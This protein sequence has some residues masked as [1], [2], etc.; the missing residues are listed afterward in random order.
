MRPIISNCSDSNSKLD[1][2]LKSK[3]SVILSF[4]VE[5]CQYSKSPVVSQ[6]NEFTTYFI[7]FS[8]IVFQSV[9]SIFTSI[10]GNDNSSR[11]KFNILTYL[12]FLYIPWSRQSKMYLLS[13]DKLFLVQV[14]LNLWEGEMGKILDGRGKKSAKEKGCGAMLSDFKRS[15]HPH[16]YPT[17][18][19][20]IVPRTRRL[21]S[22][23]PLKIISAIS[24]IRCP[25]S[26]HAIPTFTYPIF[27]DDASWRNPSTGG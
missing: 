10:K 3:Q 8:P 4:R 23:R 19:F 11:S 16:R 27:P 9:L 15:F 13:T 21:G 7:P 17:V 14:V 18:A 20:F 25:F 5:K 2:Y 26:F 24:R 12:L 6:P 22:L 1:Q